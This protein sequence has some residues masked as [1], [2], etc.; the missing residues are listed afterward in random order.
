[1]FSDERVRQALSMAIDR[2]QIVEVGMSGYT[3]PADCTGL[4]GTY[5]EWRDPA[6]YEACDWTTFDADAAAELLDEAGY[7][8]DENDVRRQPDGSEFTF[9]IAV[10][11]DSSDW[12]SVAN[13]IT[14]NLSDIGI[15]ASVDSPDW[16]SVTAG[17][18]SG[19]FETGI[20]WSANDPTP[21]QY[22][23]NLMST[24]TVTDIGEQTFENYHRFGD[25]RADELLSD[26]AG[27]TDE[28]EQQQLM[29]ELQDLYGELA[30]VVPLFPSPE[31]GAHTTTNFTGWPSEDDPYATLSTR[32]PATVKV[33]TSLEPVE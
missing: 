23:R 2:D 31:W 28:E 3:E 8:L 19:D 14:Q 29:N 21:Y 1:M 13:I 9:S 27:T 15:S 33:L 26:F 12:L 30:P 10:G 17:Y 24:E 5:E 7:E 4:T 20:V 25:E 11:S 18:E 16:A 22:F 6:A 32:S